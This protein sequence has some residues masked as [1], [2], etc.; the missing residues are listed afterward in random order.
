[1]KVN[2]HIANSS[3]FSCKFVVQ[4]CYVMWLE[5]LWMVAVNLKTSVFLAT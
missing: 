2:L 3:L 4:D 5:Q 1:M